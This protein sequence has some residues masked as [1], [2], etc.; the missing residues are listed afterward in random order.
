MAASARMF[1]AG[2]LQVHQ[3]MAVKPAGGASGVP[4]R[5]ADIVLP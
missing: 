5:R 1:E 4:L 3:V 2:K